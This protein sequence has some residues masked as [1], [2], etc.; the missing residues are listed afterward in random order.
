[1]SVVLFCGVRRF[2][3][4]FIRISANINILWN[5][6]RL[7]IP[8]HILYISLSTKQEKNRWKFI[9]LVVRSGGI[10]IIYEIKISED[11]SKPLISAFPLK[12]E[13]NDVTI[14]NLL[15]IKH[16]IH[17]LKLPNYCDIL[18]WLKRLEVLKPLLIRTHLHFNRV[19]KSKIGSN[20]GTKKP[21]GAILKSQHKLHKNYI[22]KQ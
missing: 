15:T 17:H 18:T 21:T 11:L 1:M 8:I 14:V 13:I 19:N 10:T 2:F 12:S 20:E 6:N 5:L 22:R 9:I 7:V 4:K 16:K 3:D